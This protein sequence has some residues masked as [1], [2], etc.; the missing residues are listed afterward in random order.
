MD[1]LK[2]LDTAPEPAIVDARTMGVSGDTSGD[3]WLPA[4]MC[5]Y[6]KELT[7]QIV[8]LHYSDILKY[9]ETSDYKEDIVLQSMKTMCLNSQLVATHPYLLIDHFMPKSLLTKDI[10]GH[11]SETSGKFCVL[12]DLMNLVQEYAMETLLVCRPGRTMDLLEALL[13]GNKVNIRRHDGQSIK[14]KQKK[15]RYACTCHLVPSEAAKAIALERDTR[16]GL[17]ICVDPTV[18]TQAPHIQSILAQQQ[19][20]YGRTV[21]TI[22]VAVINSIEH[23]EL[24]FGKTLDRNTRDYL[25]NVSAAMVVLRDV[26]GTLPPDLRPIYSQNLRY[27]IDW[28]DTPERPWPLPDVYPV[29]V[30]TAM[31]VERS[32][33]TEVK[34]SQNNDSLEDAFTNGKKRNHRSHGQGNGGNA[35]IS[36]YQIKR[37][38]NDYIGNPLKQDMEQLTGISNNKCKDGLLDYHLSSGTLTHKLLQAIGSV[39]ENLQLQDVELSHFAA[40]E[41][42]QTAIF[43]SHKEALSTIKKQLEDAISKKQRNN[44]LVDEYLK[45]SQNERDQLEVLEADISDLLGQLD[46]R[47]QGFKQLWD[48]LNQTENTL[49]LYRTNANAKR[50]EASYMEEELIRAEKSVAESEN[51]QT[52][53]LRDVEHLEAL[54]QDCRE[55][56]KQQQQVIK[57]KS[58][59]MEDDITQKKEAVLALQNQLGTIMEYLKQLQTPRVRSP[60]NGHRSKHRGYV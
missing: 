17:V 41:Q 59:D 22:R 9:F 34:Y 60:S 45:N 47:H 21:P 39:Y 12:R 38:K 6:Q 1:L 50:S 37:L 19:R 42:N 52:Q 54:I 44:T 55:K 23:C 33:L 48:D 25:V 53:L 13:L 35:P 18:D 46:G 32:L 27:L 7:D 36:Y 28:L 31:D 10:P 15:T 8:S 14:T 16:L 57:N 5:L 43:E 24:F 51:E 20:K 3:Y 40:V 56:D 58:K 49:A 30:Y 29:K 11:L 2:I 26:V 4:P